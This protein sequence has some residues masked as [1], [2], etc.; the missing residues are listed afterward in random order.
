[1]AAPNKA[2]DDLLKVAGVVAG[3]QTRA[4]KEVIAWQRER[5]PKNACPPSSGSTTPVT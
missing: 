4:V 5:Y 3:L 1:L 2:T